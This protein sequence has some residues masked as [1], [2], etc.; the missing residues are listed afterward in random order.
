MNSLKAEKRFRL[1]KWAEI[2]RECKTSGIKV[3]EWLAQNNISK[4]QYYYWQ[5]KVKDAC[6]E[7]MQM[8]QATF[9]ELPADIPASNTQVSIRKAHIKPK[10]K[11]VDITPMPAATLKLNCVALDIYDNASPE[12]IKNMLEA[13]IYVK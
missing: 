3:S 9:V 2:I 6:L 1:N 13:I 12:F 10:A 8:K 11:Q 5:R 4:D 7:S